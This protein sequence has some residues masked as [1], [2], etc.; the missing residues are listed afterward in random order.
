MISLQIG[1]AYMVRIDRATNRIEYRRN[2]GRET[3]YNQAG[4]A[5]KLELQGGQTGAI[6]LNI[7]T[8]SLF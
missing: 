6:P 2:V 5:P 1:N 7:A 4:G 3:D 8:G